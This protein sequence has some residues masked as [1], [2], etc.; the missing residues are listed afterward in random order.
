LSG[1]TTSRRNLP[2]RIGTYALSLRGVRVIDQSR[3][4]VTRLRMES[5]ALD[6]AEKMCGF[7]RRVV[8]G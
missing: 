8:R 6:T 2:A 3:P 5:N 7:D 4:F 1:T